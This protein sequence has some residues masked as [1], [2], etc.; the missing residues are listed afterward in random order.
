MNSNFPLIDSP[1]TLGSLQITYP[2][3]SNTPPHQLLHL[4]DSE[5]FYVDTMPYN[6]LTSHQSVIRF[7]RGQSIPDSYTLIQRTSNCPPSAPSIG[8]NY[9]HKSMHF[10]PSP[11]YMKYVGCL[12]SHTI[13]WRFASNSL[14][15]LSRHW[16]TPIINLL[17]DLV[18]FKNKEKLLLISCIKDR[19]LGASTAAWVMD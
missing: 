19:I 18:S 3:W 16:L 1:C 5:F 11:S 4:F 13:S 2:F 9:G 12:L 6:L 17:A 10:T 7:E 15:M 8:T 14:P